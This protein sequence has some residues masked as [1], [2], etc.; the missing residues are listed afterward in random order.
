MNAQGLFFNF[1]F[2]PI[3]FFPSNVA[4]NLQLSVLFDNFYQHLP[5]KK[6]KK[7]YVLFL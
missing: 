5:L 6:N 4:V 7:S 3:I 1:Y 2:V